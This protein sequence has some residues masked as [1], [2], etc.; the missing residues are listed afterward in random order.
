[1]DEEIEELDVISTDEEEEPDIPDGDAAESAL[2]DEDEQAEPEAGPTYADVDYEE[3]GTD[4]DP[5]D[6]DNTEVVTPAITETRTR[7]VTVRELI[8]DYSAESLAAY[9]AAGYRAVALYDDGTEA[10]VQWSEVVE[11]VP[12]EVVIVNEAHEVAVATNQHF[13]HGD[14]GAHVTDE[15]KDDWAAEYAKIGHGTLA[16]PTDT[17]PWHNILMNSLGILLRTGLRNLVSITKSAIAFYDGEG[18]QA[19]NV[20]ASF[21][22]TGAR[23]GKDSSSHI[24]VGDSG[25]NVYTASGSSALY[26]GLQN[27]VAIVRAGLQSAGNVVMSGLGYVQI[28]SGSSV[29]SHMGVLPGD[30]A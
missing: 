24:T 2:V 16:D 15:E 18:N 13:W 11:P 28:R 10:Y 4:E 23:I 12:E 6:A 19:G 9:E 14:D 7:S 1:M 8:S 5:V 27:A 17:R 22:T 26:A 30:A 25:M 21:G 29:V 3:A 20:L